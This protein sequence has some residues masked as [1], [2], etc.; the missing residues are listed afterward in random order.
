MRSVFEIELEKERRFAQSC[1][2]S[3]FHR[4]ATTWELLLLLAAENEHQTIG[5]YNTLAR[6]ETRYLGQSA[7]LKFLRER[8]DDRLLCFDEHEKKSMWRL[9]LSPT[10]LAELTEHLAAHYRELQEL[11][12]EQEIGLETNKRE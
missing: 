2:L 8:R 10:V 12:L 1:K 9:G 11:E 3:L 7:M 4:N 6:L 5:V